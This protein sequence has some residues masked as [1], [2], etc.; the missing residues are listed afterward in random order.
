M[1]WN[2]GTVHF[3]G[4]DYNNEA[5]YSYAISFSFLLVA[6]L[7]PLLAPIADFKKQ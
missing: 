4:R 2:N 5:L 7:S 3:I 1:L 6:L